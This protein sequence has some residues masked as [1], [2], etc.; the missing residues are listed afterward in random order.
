[1]A[2]GVVNKTVYFLKIGF[3]YPCNDDGTEYEGIMKD[4]III[5]FTSLLDSCDIRYVVSDSPTTPSEFLGNLYS[6]IGFELKPSLE[7]LFS[8]PKIHEK[9][10]EI[11]S[12]MP[13][14]EIY[15]CY[16]GRGSYIGS[17]NT[18]PGDG[19]KYLN[20]SLGV[21]CSDLPGGHKEIDFRSGRYDYKITLGA[22]NDVIQASCIDTREG[23]EVIPI[24]SGVRVIPLIEF[25]KST[26]DPQHMMLDLIKLL[27][28][29]GFLND[30]EQEKYGIY[31]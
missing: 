3:E 30:V 18:I 4:K 10:I 7:L 9:A 22:D 13:D 17:Y 25:S 24:G 19:E 23:K 12:L 28:F 5:D 8:L 26:Y 27:D 16:V 21:S 20:F 14:L 11:S 15:D 1:M 2:G 6:S 29:Y 31:L